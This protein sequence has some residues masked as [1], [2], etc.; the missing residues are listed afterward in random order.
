M[1]VIFFLHIHSF[2]LCFM[3]LPVFIHSFIH[4]FCVCC[5]CYHYSFILCFVVVAYSFIHSFCVCCCCLFIHSLFMLLPIY[6]P[7]YMCVSSTWLKCNRRSI[8]KKRSA[9][10][11]GVYLIKSRSLLVRIIACVCENSTNHAFL[12]YYYYGSKKK[13]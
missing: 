6:Y 13:I 11:H 10:T 5:C 12:H 4:S 1:C 3:L 8:V 9:D 7:M 2:I